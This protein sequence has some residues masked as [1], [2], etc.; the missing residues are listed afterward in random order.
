MKERSEETKSILCELSSKKFKKRPSLSAKM[1]RYSLE[2]RYTSLQAYSI[3]LRE[4]K[5]PVRRAVWPLRSQSGLAAAE[6]VL[7]EVTL[8]PT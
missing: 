8:I 2:L 1:I 6:P 7:K 3:L 4:P 5:G